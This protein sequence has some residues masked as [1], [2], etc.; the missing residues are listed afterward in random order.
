L[1]NIQDQVVFQLNVGINFDIRNA[2]HVARKHGRMRGFKFI[3]K[4]N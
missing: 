3:Q 4:H 2:L 1:D